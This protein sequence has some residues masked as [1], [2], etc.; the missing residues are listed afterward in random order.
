MR[1]ITGSCIALLLLLGARG[2]LAQDSPIYLNDNGGI[3]FENQKE[4]KKIKK[5]KRP[6]KAP[7]VFTKETHI[8]FDDGI[9]Y[10]SKTKEFY[11][12]QSGYQAVCL[13]TP[14][15]DLISLKSATPWRVVSL[16]GLDN[17]AISS[18]DNNYIHIDPGKHLKRG[19]STGTD[20]EDGNSSNNTP[21]VGAA[22]VSPDGKVQAL[23]YISQKSILVHYCGPKDCQDPCTESKK[24]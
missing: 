13:E 8:H 3:P 7:K 18:T 9:Q 11:V 19:G 22:F 10:D 16:S 6:A 23:G 14:V 20:L 15:G 2:A 17:Y 4:G 1:Q 12:Q 24:P 5:P 21:L